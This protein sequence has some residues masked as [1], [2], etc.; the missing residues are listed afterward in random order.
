MSG[1]SIVSQVE[2]NAKTNDEKPHL[3]HNIYTYA[4]A[5]GH[6]FAVRH[7]LEHAHK[8]TKLDVDVSCASSK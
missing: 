2:G 8:H 7:A 4:C 5:H 3:S 1:C 6:T